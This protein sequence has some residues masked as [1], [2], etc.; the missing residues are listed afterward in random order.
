MPSI[1][2]F[3]SVFGH[4]PQTRELGYSG[5]YD[6]TRLSSRS[7]GANSN[8]DI[9][10]QQPNPNQQQPSYVPIDPAVNS[11]GRSGQQF[12]LCYS[13]KKVARVQGTARDDVSKQK[14]SIQQNVFHHQFDVQEGTMLCINAKGRP[15]DYCSQVLELT[16]GANGQPKDLSFTTREECFRSSLTVHL[17]NCNWATDDWRGYLDYLEEAVETHVGLDQADFQSTF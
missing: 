10:A 4:P 5:F 8:P 12:Q 9:F 6:Q 17:M 11:L 3:L 7:P 2:D 16:G 1:I 15:S 13:L 14:W